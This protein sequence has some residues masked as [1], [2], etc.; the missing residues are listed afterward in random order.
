MSFSGRNLRKIVSDIR[1]DVYTPYG[2][3]LTEGNFRETIDFLICLCYYFVQCLFNQIWLRLI[4]FLGWLDERAKSG[5]FIK[6]VS[7]NILAQSLLRAHPELYRR[8]NEDYLT[9]NHRSFALIKELNRF[10]ADVIPDFSILNSIHENCPLFYQFSYVI[11]FC[12]CKKLKLNNSIFLILNSENSVGCE[13][14]DFILW[15]R[16]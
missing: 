12:V 9:W 4:V 14:S 6:V 13:Q 8:C 5:T 15:I 16:F 10:N 7:Y 1:Q 2:K 11:R 3:W